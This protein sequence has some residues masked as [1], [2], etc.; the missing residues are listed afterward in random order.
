[1]GVCLILHRVDLL[2][3]GF[4]GLWIYTS[5]RKSGIFRISTFLDFDLNPEHIII[6]IIM[7]LRGVWVINP[8]CDLG[9]G[10]KGSKVIFS[11]WV[12]QSSMLNPRSWTA[13]SVHEVMCCCNY[14]AQLGVH[15]C[16]EGKR[17]LI[18]IAE[19]MQ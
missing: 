14:V 11:R 3:H 6:I 1:M 4:A 9:N 15:M 5:L 2:N 12:L 7:S 19:F 8:E 16:I 17:I 18:S 13:E 10:K